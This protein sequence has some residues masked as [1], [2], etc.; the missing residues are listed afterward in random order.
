[1]TFVIGVSGY[2]HDS[3]ICLTKDAVLLE[4]LKEEEF[5]RVKGTKGF[6]HR[7][8][9]FLKNKYDLNDESID[10]VVFYEKPLRGWATRVAQSLRSPRKSSKLLSHQLKQFWNG[11]IG[12]ARDFQKILP[13]NENKIAY[14]PHHLSHAL[15]S[16]PFVDTSLLEKRILHFV[17]DGVGDDE[18]QSIFLTEGT[19]AERV[20]S[21][22]YPHSL[23]LFYSAITDFC[24]FLVNE[25]EYKLMALAAYGEPRHEA[26]MR[27]E[28]IRQIGHR[29][30]LDLTWFDFHHTPERSYSEK[31]IEHFGPP[32]RQSNL[33][34]IS[35]PDFKRAADLA[36]SAQAT[37]EAVL[38]ET[39]KWGLSNY[40]CDT[41]T[42]T[43]GV[44][45]NSLAIEAVCKN[46]EFTV[47][48]IVPPSPGDSGAAVGA[49][50]FGNIISAK[51][52][53]ST[54]DIFFSSAPENVNMDLFNLLFNKI[55]DTDSMD[56]VVD[57]DILSGQIIC[58]FF[59][60]KEIGPRA[61]GN[62]SILCAGNDQRAVE[63][64]NRTVKR[65]EFFR[66][67]A[68]LMLEETAKKY[69]MLSDSGMKNY[70][71][72]ALT[73]HASENFPD[74]YSPA[75]HVDRSARI[76]IMLDNTHYVYK[77]L[78]RLSGKVDMLINTSFNVAGDPI[79]HDIIDCYTNMYR[80][81][82][83]SLIT[84]DGYYKL[85][86]MITPKVA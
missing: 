31:F 34:E 55:A 1:M 79:V 61:L 71:W 38:L 80:L 50:V 21:E 15:S 47:P 12:F 72:M 9:R 14:C 49:A 36:K 43:G 77:I 67:L 6:P 20:F 41:V 52:F 65:R 75:L 32:I 85:N 16:T 48:V 60:K 76:Q 59:N 44:A 13:I 86:S 22:K 74:E 63:K 62:R 51:R 17:L 46:P 19:T 68:P 10:K 33:S 81:G 28:M 8:L 54:E 53:I 69:F 57:R 25:G 4:F 3:S 35:H 37:V 26:I 58:T 82:I 56:A 5:T 45:H 83:D 18:C 11:P 40:P 24:G 42:I 78:N 30:Q 64:L 84:E 23:G 27:N 2:F 73:T 29:V 39:I 66:P 7:S 70:R